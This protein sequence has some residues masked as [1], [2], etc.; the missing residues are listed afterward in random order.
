M[1]TKLVVQNFVLIDNAELN[2]DKG[3]TVIT[4]ETGSGKSIMLG[5]LKLISGDRADSKMIRDA[6]QKTIIE[7]FFNINELNLGSFFDENDLDYADETI[8]RREILPSGK[9]RA[10]VNDS[11]VALN[12]LKSLML[13]LIHIHSQHNTINIKDKKFQ[14]NF[15]DLLA[16]TGTLKEDYLETFHEYTE[17]QKKIEELKNNLALNQ[18]NL[19][20]N[21]FL[22]EELSLLNLYDVDYSVL[23]E[24]L[25][26][27]N[28]FED[29]KQGYDLLVNL[30]DGENGIYEQ[31]INAGKLLKSN[32]EKLGQ[33][34]E[35]LNQVNIELNDIAATAADDLVDLDE[36]NVDP[37]VLTAKMDAYFSALKKHNCDNQAQLIQVLNNLK[38]EV[39]NVEFADEKLLQYEKEA[40]KLHDLLSK[41][42]KS[43]T[44]LRKK[45]AEII[46]LELVNI[47]DMLKLNEAKIAFDFT[48]KPFSVDGADNV[49]F[50]FT[51]NKGME[52]SDIAKSASGGE[53]ARLMLAIQFKLSEKQKLPTVIFDEI[54]TGVSGEV[55]QKIGDLLKMMGERMQ[56]MAITHLPQV[57]SSGDHH[58]LVK[59]A[60]TEEETFTAFI[61]LNLEERILEIAKLMSGDQ[62]SDAAIENARKLM[63][64]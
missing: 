59:K 38:A 25:N 56:L 58:V 33:L 2:F 49:N 53:L 10:F 3:F 54:D 63:K 24:D 64:L 43:L 6:K 36:S 22:L 7:A 40:K 34:I 52:P 27:A 37:I 15:L 13:N 41:K 45:N 1:L 30:I 51:P 17:Q 39:E 4:G 32:D 50:L 47:L 57:A 62:I 8:V 5:A 46:S 61:D 21:K 18:R 14:L 26:R 48:A 42:A 11:P 55:A 23:E 16:G 19:D 60:S 29:I 31:I 20:F 44:D 12:V 9:S 28:N 35:R